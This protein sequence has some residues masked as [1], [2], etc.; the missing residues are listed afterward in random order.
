[1]EYPRRI[2]IDNP[3]IWQHHQRGWKYVIGLLK[4]HLHSPYGVKFLSSVDDA[5]VQ[6]QFIEEP[7]VGFLH[8]VPDTHGRW[9]PDL[10]RIFASP[11]WEAN[12]R[13]C[14][15]LFVLSEYLRSFVLEHVKDIPVS[16][17]YY[18]AAQAKVLFDEAKFGTRRPRKMFHIGQYLRDYQAF[19]DLKAT[20]YHKYLVWHHG[21]NIE[22]V[23][24]NDSV[25]IVQSL[26]MPEYDQLLADGLV[27]LKLKDSSAN[28]VIVECIAANTPLL[29][30]PVGGVSEYL[31]KDY[32]LYYRDLG[33]ACEIAANTNL[34][35]AASHYL[36]CARAKTLTSREY[37]L[38]SLV[39]SE[40][41]ENLAGVMG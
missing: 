21:V 9:F 1:M 10:G 14:R 17:L 26:S 27:F 3:H 15:G 33:E 22:D 11:V 38:D 31:G 36:S 29:I 7:W 37:F 30:N 12:L 34:I 24:T 28:T 19:Y 25:D 20:G 40:V 41:Y 8:Q 32:P 5:V 35:V 39:T 2:K 6:G 18:P 13:F 4:T 23:L 16:K